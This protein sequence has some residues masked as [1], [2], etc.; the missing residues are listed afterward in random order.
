MR[1]FVYACVGV[2]AC[3]VCSLLMLQADSRHGPV[4]GAG[5]GLGPQV[6][7]ATMAARMGD[8]VSAAE[9]RDKLLDRLNTTGLVSQ[10]KV[11]TPFPPIA[12]CGDWAPRSLCVR[13][14]GQSPRQIR[15]RL[16]HAWAARLDGVV[17]AEVGHAVQPSGGQVRVPICPLHFSPVCFTVCVAVLLQPC[18]RPPGSQAIRLHAVCVPP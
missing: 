5:L 16:A 17:E 7:A 2:T 11:P 10:M 4:R 14:L 9:L 13:C 3:G 18:R 8:G 6:T 12:C 15:V 1:V